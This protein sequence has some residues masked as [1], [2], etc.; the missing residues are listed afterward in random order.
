MTSAPPIHS[1]AAPPELPPWA[2]AVVPPMAW[3]LTCGRDND[4]AAAESGRVCVCPAVAA[5]AFVAG[6]A[7]PWDGVESPRDVVE[8]AAGVVVEGPPAVPVCGVVPVDAGCGAGGVGASEPPPAGVVVATVVVG[9]V[10]TVLV[11]VVV[12]GGGPASQMSA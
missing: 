1:G 9:E 4:G 3:M 7:D 12:V 2:T 6:C 11:V 5:A 10:G 8:A